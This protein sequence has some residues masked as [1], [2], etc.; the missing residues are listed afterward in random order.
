MCVTSQMHAAA[1]DLGDTNSHIFVGV[2]IERKAM[3]HGQDIGWA[4]DHEA[5]PVHGCVEGQQLLG[6]TGQAAATTDQGADRG[7]NQFRVSGSS[8]S[9]SKQASD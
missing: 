2:I 8:S 6:L 4:T 9:G 5:P 7:A 1:A 3:D